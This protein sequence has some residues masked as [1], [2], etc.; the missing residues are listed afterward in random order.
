MPTA[1]GPCSTS[2]SWSPS[3]ATHSKE[4]EHFVKATEYSSVAAFESVKV[5]SDAIGGNLIR[6]DP[7]DKE[8]GSI[9]DLEE[10]ES[11]AGRVHN[12]RIGLQN[13][14]DE[15]EAIDPQNLPHRFRNDLRDA[16]KQAADADL[17]LADAEVGFELL[18]GILGADGP[19]NYLLGFPEHLGTTRDRWR[20][21]A[22]LDPRDRQR[23]RVAR[24]RQEGRQ[25]GLR[26]RRRRTPAG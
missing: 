15:L 18:P 9:I 19:R 14:A 23:P 25:N 22:V 17:R 16:L 11:L 21:P 6:P 10:V 24:Q 2:P 26:R 20:D 13:S 5:A 12:I 1:E 7:E 8:N 3:P 4:I